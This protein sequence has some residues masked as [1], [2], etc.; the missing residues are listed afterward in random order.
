VAEYE[1][2]FAWLPFFY[3]PIKCGKRLEI[4][5]KA[6][7]YFAFSARPAVPQVIEP[8]EGI[9]PGNKIIYV[10]GVA[11][12]VFP[13]TMDEKEDGLDITLGEPA[14]VVDIG[15]AQ[16]FKSTFDMLHEPSSFYAGHYVK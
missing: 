5:R 4:I 7:D 6:L 15:I 16:T 9:P 2:G 14:L 1:D 13:Q 11:P 8:V 10:I 12:A 3:H